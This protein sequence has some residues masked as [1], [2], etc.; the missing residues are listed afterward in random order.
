[1][2]MGFGGVLSSAPPWVPS[3]TQ[4]VDTTTNGASTP[5]AA[6]ATARVAPTYASHARRRSAYMR[7]QSLRIA[8]WT[9]TSGAKARTLCST[10]TGSVTSTA[11]IS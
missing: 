8:Q 10:A 9:T 2:L 3:N 1:M 6:S 4:S 11:S 7:S 5:L